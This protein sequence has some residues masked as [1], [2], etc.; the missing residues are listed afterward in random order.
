MAVLVP[1]TSMKRT[2]TAKI[3]R[4]WRSWK[5]FVQQCLSDELARSQYAMRLIV[6]LQPLEAAACNS[7]ILALRCSFQ[8]WR[9]A[10]SP[11]RELIG[12]LAVFTK[13][14]ALSQVKALGRAWSC[15]LLQVCQLKLEDHNRSCLTVH[16]QELLKLRQQ[17]G[18]RHLAFFFSGSERQL[19]HWGF[20][21]WMTVFQTEKWRESSARLMHKVVG[22][23]SQRALSAGWGTWLAALR[24]HRQLC[25]QKEMVH[26]HALAMLFP[27]TSNTKT[28]KAKIQRAWQFWRRFVQQCLSD[29]LVRS[30]YA[31]RLVIGLQPLEA[32]AC[33]S[34]NFLVRCSF[35]K[36]RTVILKQREMNALVATLTKILT[37]SQVKAL[38]RAWSC[39][40]LQVCQLKLE[41]HNRSCLTVHQQELLK[42]R[43]Q[44][45]VKQLAFFFSGC[46]T[47]LLHW[48]FKAW[49]TVFQTEK[50]RESSA[51]VMHKV[52]GRLSQKALAAGWGTWLAA[53]R[54]HRQL[55]RQKEMVHRN[56]LAVLF[57]NTSNTKTQKVKIRRAWQSWRGFVQQYLSDELAR[58]QYAMRLVIGL[59]PLEAAACNSLNFL[60]RCSFQ[61][62]RAAILKQR[63]MNAL[64]ATLTKILTL[65]QVKA[66][67]RAWNCWLLHT[68]QQNLA[69]Y[70]R[71]CLTSHQQAL[72][73]L[74][75]Q[76]GARHLVFLFSGSER[77]LLRLGFKTLM[78]VVQAAKWREFNAQLV[79]KVCRRLSQKTLAAG[80]STWLAALR[81]HWQNC[82]QK[83]TMQRYAIAVLLPGASKARAQTFKIQRAWQSWKEFVR[84]CLSVELA[85]SQYAMCLIAGLQP[86]EAAACT[87]LNSVLRCSF[88]KW[89]AAVNEQRK[90]HDSL[91]ALTN[92][93]TIS[94][95]KS[96]GR[97]WSFW[98]V[99]VCRQKL[100]DHNQSSLSAHQQELRLLRNQTGAR[101]LVFLL[102]ASEKQLLLCGFK[103]WI[104]AVWQIKDREHTLLLLRKACTRLSQRLLSLGWGTWLVSHKA[105]EQMHKLAHTVHICA[106][107][108]LLLQAWERWKHKIATA[109]ALCYAAG[110]IL[111]WARR[112]DMLLIRRCFQKWYRSAQHYFHQYFAAEVLVQKIVRC[113]LRSQI[114]AFATWK[115]ASRS[116]GQSEN[117]RDNSLKKLCRVF[118]KAL[119]SHRS[120]ALLKALTLW[121][122]QTRCLQAQLL[123]KARKSSLLKVSLARLQQAMGYT[124]RKV[125]KRW[126]HLVQLSK[127]FESS[128]RIIAKV[129]KRMQKNKI[130]CSFNTWKTVV[131][132]VARKTLIL[133]R[134]VNRLEHLQVLCYWKVWHG[135]VQENRK[136]DALRSR[137]LLLMHV[138]IRRLS[139]RELLNA[140]LRWKTYALFREMEDSQCFKL[141]KADELLASAQKAYGGFQDEF[142]LAQSARNKA[143]TELLLVNR[144]LRNRGWILKESHRNS[145]QLFTPR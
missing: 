116:I 39:W 111:R 6:G 108:S 112:K 49:M 52:L 118:D 51:R 63:E 55:G 93:R 82:R 123:E 37:L 40:L 135:W 89:R 4:A 107:R 54:A 3:Q 78:A 106:Q 134:V 110:M 26:R 7:R 129:I 71:S 115:S 74:R 138:A 20:K 128:T 32:A 113:F 31:M 33:S 141:A 28:Q 48:G 92:M 139:S 66:R 126:L 42:L 68:C 109:N 5:G 59:Q 144:N 60:V 36:W 81:A 105:R 100:M 90:L 75:H 87:N 43:Q 143:E 18:V 47:Q 13:M 22:R 1:T 130:F 11:S 145:N 25:H 91:A 102:S 34:L 69:D 96:L 62:W 23:L 57:P 120:L 97:A 56:A 8:K 2:D 45:G 127:I 124:L 44:A 46:E 67:S 61:K 73:E 58:S 12:L 122:W 99:H 83:E 29:E 140:I 95:V 117:E 50:W 131:M 132:E 136:R 10:T 121:R 64:L 53:L 70:K 94:Q 125:L 80:W 86:L 38:G 21:A 133:C 24:A 84:Q 103:R 76:A 65:S 30:R 72:L 17:A 77:Q 14:T 88:Q 85:R 19:L 35:Q 15:W 119:R 79:H 41:D 114:K 98:L 142:H 16:Q 27:N 101:Q 104:V 137:S 9:A